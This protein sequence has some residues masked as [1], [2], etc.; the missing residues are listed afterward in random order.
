MIHKDIKEVREFLDAQD[1]FFDWVCKNA[2]DGRSP[3][4]LKNVRLYGRRSD[5]KVRITVNDYDDGSKD[6]DVYITYPVSRKDDR[7]LFS[8]DWTDLKYL[9]DRRKLIKNYLISD[10]NSS[11]KEFQSDSKTELSEPEAEAYGQLKAE[12]DA[13][14]WFVDAL[15]ERIV[16]NPIENGKYE[17]R[18]HHEILYFIK[19]RL[20][21]LEYNLI[22][23]RNGNYPVTFH[24]FNTDKP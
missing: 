21:D 5:G 17:R 24:D 13:L 11:G 3:D 19:A 16:I 20:F 10:D 6:C 7:C 9:D 15:G 4:S 22:S 23:I 8:C 1:R 14:K 18:K 2:I 12:R